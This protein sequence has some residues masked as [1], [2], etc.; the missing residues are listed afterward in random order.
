MAQHIYRIFGLES[1]QYS[2]V[3]WA[4]SRIKPPVDSLT[5]G[6]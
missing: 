5:E 1:D 4:L 6:Q 3:I 2:I